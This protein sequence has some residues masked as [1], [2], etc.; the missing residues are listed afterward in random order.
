MVR[1]FGTGGGVTNGKPAS[2]MIFN[3]VMDAVIREVIEE[4][5]G[6]LESNHIMVWAV[7]ERN[8]VFYADDRRIAGR[9]PDWVQEALEMTVDMFSRVGL[10]TNLEKTRAM[11]STPGLF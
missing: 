11:V 2:P 4:V 1:P 3:T 9:D 10:E 6:P 5:F 8:L 7:G